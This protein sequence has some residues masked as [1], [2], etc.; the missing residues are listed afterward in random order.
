MRQIYVSDSVLCIQRIIL[1]KKR[2]STA[3]N[4]IQCY[5]NTAGTKYRCTLGI[6]QH[7]RCCFFCVFVAA[8]FKSKATWTTPLFWNAASKYRS[9]IQ[10]KNVILITC[11]PL[12][13]NP[14]CCSQAFVRPTSVHINKSN[15]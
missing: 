10:W 7:V 11:N 2:K 1:K 12:V 3:L 13:P 6:L 15:T 9:S 5:V 8:V 4:K 14:G